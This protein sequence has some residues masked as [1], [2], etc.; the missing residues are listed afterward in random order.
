[1]AHHGKPFLPTRIPVP[2]VA[3]IRSLQCFYPHVTTPV[4]SV[5]LVQPFHLGQ[6]C[7]RV[8]PSNLL[9]W[10]SDS[11]LWSNQFVKRERP[12]PK[13]SVS[14]ARAPSRTQFLWHRTLA[15]ICGAQAPSPAIAHASWIAADPGREVFGFSDQSIS[16]SPDHPI[17]ATPTPP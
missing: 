12:P 10:T 14:W 15:L 17:F 1:M 16:R 5:P 4:P 9:T 2:F 7:L 6:S 11:D 3:T 13:A 8:C